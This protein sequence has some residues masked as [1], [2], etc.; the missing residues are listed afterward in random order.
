MGFFLHSSPL[1]KLMR[2]GSANRID[3]F[4]SK[5]RSEFD[6]RLTS[7]RIPTIQSTRRYRFLIYINLKLIYFWLNWPFWYKIDLLIDFNWSIVNSLIEIGRIISKIGRIWYKNVPNR[8]ICIKF[9]QIRLNSTNF[10]SNST[11][12][13]NSDQDFESDSSRRVIEPLKS[14]RKCWLKV[15][16]ITIKVDLSI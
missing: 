2:L 6:H 15:D 8:Q 10:W 4:K 16:S 3:G 9:N 1:T 5:S 7:I 11:L 13:S 14:T 12:D